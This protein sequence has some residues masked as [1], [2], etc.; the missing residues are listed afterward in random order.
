MFTANVLAESGE[1]LYADAGHGLALICAADGTV[2][3]LESQGLPLGILVDSEWVDKTE[4][5]HIG[6]TFVIFSDGVLDLFDGTLAAIDEVALMTKSA[7]T[8]EA[9]IDQIFDLADSE[10]LD[11]DISVVVIRRLALED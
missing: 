5:L 7:P 3:Q 8:C 10:S 1:V 2:T 6:D 9:L 11:D 4:Q